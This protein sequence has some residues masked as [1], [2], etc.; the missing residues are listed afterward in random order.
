MF[1]VFLSLKKQSKAN[2][3]ILR[4]VVKMM[5][6]E[7]KEWSQKVAVILLVHYQLINMEI[8]NVMH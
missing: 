7:K 1:K 2:I 4:V 5:E 6:P 8:F 3:H